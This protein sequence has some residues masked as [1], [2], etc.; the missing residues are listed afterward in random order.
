MRYCN[1][2]FQL[3]HYRLTLNNYIVNGLVKTVLLA[4]DIKYIGLEIGIIHHDYTSYK[5]IISYCVC[6]R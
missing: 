5:T 1:L 3:M 4:S 6:C 2:L